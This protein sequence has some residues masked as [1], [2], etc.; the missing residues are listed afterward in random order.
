MVGSHFQK[1]D[2]MGIIL[3]ITGSFS[4]VPHNSIY[5]LGIH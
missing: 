5:D 4:S 3:I 1:I 2:K